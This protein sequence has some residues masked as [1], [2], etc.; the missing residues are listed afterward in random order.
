MTVQCNEI[1]DSLIFLLRLL[2]HFSFSMQEIKN[3]ESKPVLEV[4]TGLDKGLSNFFCKF[5]NIFQKICERFEHF[6]SLLFT[7]WIRFR[8]RILIKLALDADLDPDLLIRNTAYGFIYQ[9]Y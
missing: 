1:F 6:S 4:E 3:A 7:P 2:S 8:N 9:L 5:L